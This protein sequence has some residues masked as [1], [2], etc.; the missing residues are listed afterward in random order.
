MNPMAVLGF[1]WD[2][3]DLIPLGLRAIEISSK[4]GEFLVTCF[5]TG[6]DLNRA[7]DCKKPATQKKNNI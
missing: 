7:Q 2:G 5:F 1:S 3:S 4:N 6:D